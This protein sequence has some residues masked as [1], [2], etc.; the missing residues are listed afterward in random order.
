MGTE[1]TEGF[2][3]ED[4]ILRQ[5]NREILRGKHSVG[6]VAFKK[7]IHALF[8]DSNY[9]RLV[10]DEWN[11][12]IVGHEEAGKAT[13]PYET[14]HYGNVGLKRKSQ[15]KDSLREEVV[16]FVRETMGEIKAQAK[17]LLS[18]EEINPHKSPAMNNLDNQLLATGMAMYS[19]FARGGIYYKYR[20]GEKELDKY[21]PRRIA[22]DIINDVVVRF[23]AAE[24]Q[25]KNK[26]KSRRYRPT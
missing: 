18:S 19:N 5:I 15:G 23:N 10:V 1:T 13:S 24:T 21:Q 7:F 3:A 25:R 12:F 6:R 2:S 22:A 20:R 17:E 14:H 26:I 8:T 16:A 4:Q 9:K 11:K